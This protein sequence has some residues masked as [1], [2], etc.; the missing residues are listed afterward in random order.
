LEPAQQGAS[1]VIDC[2]GTQQRVQALG[3]AIGESNDMTQ[4]AIHVGSIAPRAAGKKRI[5][6]LGG[7]FAGAYV[8]KHLEKRLGATSDVEIAVIANY[9]LLF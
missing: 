9:K 2:V 7:G 6:I 1:L 3:W 4:T 8:A 5:L